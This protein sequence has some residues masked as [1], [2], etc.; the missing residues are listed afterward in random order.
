MSAT[1]DALDA[2][3]VL[4]TEDRYL[5]EALSACRRGRVLFRP[6]YD[7]GQESRDVSEHLEAVELEAQSA[8]NMC[9]NS[10][11]VEL[12]NWCKRISDRISLARRQGTDDTC[13]VADLSRLTTAGQEELDIQCDEYASDSSRI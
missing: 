1:T 12:A 5:V 7:Y 4:L 3:T 8:S 6:D 9:A 2:A 10:G 11:L 13:A